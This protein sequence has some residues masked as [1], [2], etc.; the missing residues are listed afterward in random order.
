MQNAKSTS[1]NKSQK[2][3]QPRHAR[4]GRTPTGWLSQSCP[5]N[6][7]YKS[8]NQHWRKSSTEA[9]HP[10]HRRPN[11]S[12]RYVDSN[13]S[14][15]IVLSYLW[16]PNPAQLCRF[17]PFFNSLPPDLIDLERY[18]FSSIDR[19]GYDNSTPLHRKPHNINSV[20]SLE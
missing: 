4:Q 20:L 9:S 18:S 12:A 7:R 16:N 17:F 8:T 14:D 1:Y 15:Q 11:L 2:N 6:A 3:R 10:R 5:A 13:C 19:I